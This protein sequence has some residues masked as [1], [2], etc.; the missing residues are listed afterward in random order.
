MKTAM[1]MLEISHKTDE[2]LQSLMA[3][4]R[5]VNCIV[6]GGSVRITRVIEARITTTP[7]DGK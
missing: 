5:K 2:G 4:L 3:D 1:V 7:P 6:K